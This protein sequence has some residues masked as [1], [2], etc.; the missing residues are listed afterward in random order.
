M[1]RI[2]SFPQPPKATLSALVRHSQCRKRANYKSGHAPQWWLEDDV[3]FKNPASLDIGE[4]LSL[5][6]S[7][8]EFVRTAEEFEGSEGEAISGI[9]K[10]NRE[11]DDETKKIKCFE[12]VAAGVGPHSDSEVGSPFIPSRAPSKVLRVPAIA[13]RTSLEAFRD[14]SV[15]P[16]DE[17]IL[18]MIAEAEFSIKEYISRAH[19]ECDQ[20]HRL[21]A[22]REEY[23]LRRVKLIF[24]RVPE[25][26]HRSFLQIF[27]ETCCREEGGERAKELLMALF[28]NIVREPGSRDAVKRAIEGD[29][30]EA[31]RRDVAPM[32]SESELK[33]GAGM[34]PPVSR[35]MTPGAGWRSA[36][37]GRG[38][39]EP[40][41]MLERQKIRRVERRETLTVG[42]MASREEVGR[43][44]QGECNVKS[45]PARK[46]KEG[47]V[48]VPLFVSEN[49]S[50]VI[51]TAHGDNSLC[52]GNS[53]DD[54]SESVL[55]MALAENRKRGKVIKK[56]LAEARRGGARPSVKM[57]R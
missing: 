57:M 21:I 2:L 36:R 35:K 53:T 50:P 23:I 52:F 49:M 25:T 44:E 45:V 48:L 30:S 43:F 13:P 20:N 56:K 10:E 29:I 33:R 6:E 27:I 8:R 26:R 24:M 28:R 54:E 51:D 55:L 16:G 47:D 42:R 19:E 37:T 17:E 9:A 22:D 15:L 32:S 34:H 18:K 41:R 46:V 38:R 7:A 40:H 12:K 3:P 4:A 5:L 11:R 14:A 39:S 31:K 1:K